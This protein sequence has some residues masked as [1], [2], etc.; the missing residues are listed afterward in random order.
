M[1]GGGA[2]PM[3]RWVWL[4][5]LAAGLLFFKLGA[6]PYIET[7]EARYAEIAREMLETRDFV[8]PHLLYIK[9]FHKPPLTYWL[10]AL[11]FR[12]G[13]VNDLSGRIGLA[14]ASLGILWL[15]AKTARL[16]F[17]QRRAIAAGSVL[18]L[19]AS[20]L[21]LALSR[22]LTTDIYLALFTLAAVYFHWRWF[23]RSGR[24]RDALV[25]GLA[26][27]LA[28]LT[29][30]PVVLI[31]FL[32]PWLVA[33]LGLGR[34]PAPLTAPDAGPGEL[35]AR[36]RGGWLFLLVPLVVFAPWLLAV[37]R[38][39][40][41][42][43]DYFLRQQIAGRVASPSFHRTEPVYFHP[44]V[45]FAGMLFAFTYYL[46]GV[47]RALRRPAELRGRPALL[48]LLAYTLVP[49]ILF[50]FN[51][52]KLP[53]YM[54]PAMPWIAILAVVAL[55]EILPGTRW[56]RPL[57]RVNAALLLALAAALAA[58][59]LL[60]HSSPLS[61]AS[62]YWIALAAFGAVILAA[63]PFW[64]RR[65][66]TRLGVFAGFNIV[67]F[68]LGA[69][70]IPSVSESVNGFEEIARGIESHARTAESPNDY[71][72]ISYRR[73]LPS[74]TFYTGKR[75]IQIV[76]DRETQFEAASD[77][78]ILDAYLSRDPARIPKLMSESELTF[79]VIRPAGLDEL[80]RQFPGLDDAFRCIHR[81]PQNLVFCNR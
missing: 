74:L 72:I 79:L 23:F 75:V 31:F 57:H 2:G 1:N 6:L 30:G 49:L 35:P 12:L 33:R 67:L 71:R 58:S 18:V 50:T 10:T 19:L 77:R 48:L 64:L 8:T 27:G 80:R 81:S 56:E 59:P 40:P 7:S 41:S 69:M 76:H 42:L 36:R 4:L 54:L 60:R 34:S 68:L 24:A 25:A 22:A 13:G 17:P 62:G 21:Y 14:L 43:L 44:A 63:S 70:M 53:P 61:L 55:G 51:A 20:P 39:N 3:R 5:P 38:A 47:I 28:W 46:G 16:L 65:P 78:V 15:T 37:V 29:K 9:H 26:L 45:L 66:R 11:A 32:A 73:R 52:S